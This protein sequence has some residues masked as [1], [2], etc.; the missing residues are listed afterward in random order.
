MDTTDKEVV[1]LKPTSVFLSFL[2]AQKPKN[3]PLPDLATLQQ[4]CSAYVITKH[5]YEEDLVDEI[6][7][8]YPT[9]FNYELCRW[10]GPNFKTEIEGSFLDFLCCFKFEVHSQIIL[11]DP[12]I[13]KNQTVICVKPQSILVKWMRSCIEDQGELINILDHINA[14]EL[15]ENSTVL[16]KNFQSPV[17]I[18]KFLQ[19][20]YRSLFS[21][22]MMRMCDKEEQWPALEDFQTFKRYFHIRIHNNLVNLIK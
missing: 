10:L 11:M 14:T 12:S 15:I 13:Q 5:R 6:E 8:H 22:E 17:A 21:I 3:K 9:M 4:D 16:I 1:I 2:A 19:Q 20:Y 18:E 7:E